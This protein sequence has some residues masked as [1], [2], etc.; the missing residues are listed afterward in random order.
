M[1]INDLLFAAQVRT[2]AGEWQK[3]RY[4]AFTAGLGNG[5]DREDQIE[6]WRRTNT[7]AKAIE[8]VYREFKS[9]ASMI[10]RWEREAGEKTSGSTALD[11]ALADPIRM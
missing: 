5:V 7:M 11:E 9:V 2:L 10:E 4:L 6:E 1:E 8:D 3:A